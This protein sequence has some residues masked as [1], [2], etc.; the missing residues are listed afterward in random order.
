MIVVNLLVRECIL[1]RHHLHQSLPTLPLSEDF[2]ST[3]FQ[4]NIIH[5]HGHHNPLGDCGLLCGG[6]HLHT[7]QPLLEL[8]H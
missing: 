8:P 3:T 5:C 4:I 6:L 2:R 1:H 7:S